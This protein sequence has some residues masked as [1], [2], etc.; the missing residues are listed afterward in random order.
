M[1][2]FVRA[3]RASREFG[4]D[5]VAERSFPAMAGRYADFPQPLPAPLAAALERQG[6][7]RLYCHQAEAIER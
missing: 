6:I 5:V 1:I 7:G 2:E 3:L 4:S